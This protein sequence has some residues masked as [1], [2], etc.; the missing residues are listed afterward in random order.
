MG[1]FQEPRQLIV[2]EDLDGAA[3]VALGD[4][5]GE[6]APG[7]LLPV[8]VVDSVE[9]VELPDEDHEGLAVGL[10]VE[11]VV[12]KDSFGSNGGEGTFQGVVL[13]DG[14]VLLPV[15]LIEH[16]CIHCQPALTIS[17]IDLTFSRSVSRLSVEYTVDMTSPFLL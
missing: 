10:A 14:H 4:A 12:A 16:A 15:G 8:A 2:G 9:A 11:D 5:L 7:E 17:C 1:R 6:L 13:R 3:S